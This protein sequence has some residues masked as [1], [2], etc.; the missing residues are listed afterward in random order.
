MLLFVFNMRSVL[1]YGRRIAP[2]YISMRPIKW[3][4]LLA[5][6]KRRYEGFFAST[7]RRGKLLH[8]VVTSNKKLVFHITPQSKLI[9][10]KH[11]LLRLKGKLK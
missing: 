11:L 10:Y 6:Q 3:L 9:E 2:I 4:Y 1:I 7:G 8:E 5:S